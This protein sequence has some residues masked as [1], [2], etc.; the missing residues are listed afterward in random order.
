MRSSTLTIAIILLVTLFITGCATFRSGIEGEFVGAGEKNYGA[1]KV[2]VLFIFSHFKQA[3]G[4]D[5]I[6]KMES[7]RQIIDDFDDLFIDAMGELSNVGRYSTYTE[8]ASDVGDSKRRAE[9]D[10]MIA[11]HDY[12]FRI[13]FN[14]ENSFVQHFLGNVFSTVSA[15]LLPMPYSMDYST[16]VDVFNSEDILIKSYTREASLTKWVQTMLI[17]IYPFHTEERKK[18]EIYIECMHDIFKQIETERIISER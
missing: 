11:T 3:K 10:S 17:F 16:T 7:E 15:T 5:A 9:K 2:S 8:F 14:R 6:A 12:I 1:E 18:E 13:K 4:Y